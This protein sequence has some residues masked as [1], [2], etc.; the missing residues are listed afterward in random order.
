VPFQYWRADA[1]LPSYFD[2]FVATPGYGC[3]TSEDAPAVLDG[4][5]ILDEDIQR[6]REDA[7]AMSE[8]DA[9]WR[10]A[11]VRRLKTARNG[12]GDLPSLSEI[13]ASAAFAATTVSMRVAWEIA[14]EAGLMDAEECMSLAAAQVELIDRAL[15][16][17]QFSP[18]GRQTLI[19]MQAEY[20]NA[21]RL[22]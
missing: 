15:R 1:A 3:D 4:S 20:R 18:D 12:D 9:S 22:R 14:A 2:T 16:S 8:R 10:A 21:A 11:I 19:E 6:A 7:V 5:R 13:E 17:A